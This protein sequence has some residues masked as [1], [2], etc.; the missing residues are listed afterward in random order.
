MTTSYQ[1]L[2]QVQPL[3]S[4]EL[5]HM[6]ALNLQGTNRAIYLGGTLNGAVRATVKGGDLVKLPDGTTWL[7]TQSL[8][9]FYSTVGWTK[10]AIT[11]QDGS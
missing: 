3:S 10:A 1:V 4:G 2:A 11:L 9:P 7:V 6:D 5:R 8:E